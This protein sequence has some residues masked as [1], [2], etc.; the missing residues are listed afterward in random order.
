[1][2]EDGGKDDRSRP[3]PLLDQGREPLEP[4]GRHL[5]GHVRDGHGEAQVGL[6]RA[7]AEDRLRVGHARKRPLHPHP[8][9]GEQAHE[10]G[11]DQLEDGLH[12]RK[13]H[14]DVDLGELGLAVGAQVLVAEAADDLEIAVHPR[15]HEDL[16][17]DLGRLGQRVELSVVDPRRYQ[18]VARALRRRLREHR[19]L[20]L[21]EARLVHVAAHLHGHAVAQLQVALEPGPAQVEIAILEPNVLGG[22]ELVLDGKGWRLRFGQD[23]DLAGQHLEGARGQLRVHRLRGP[24]R[25]LAHDRENVLAAH[26]VRGAVGLGGHLGPGHHLADP[27]A[28]AEVQE[29]HPPEV[30]S[31]GHPAHEGDGLPDRGVG[32]RPAH[33]GAGQRALGLSHGASPSSARGRAPRAR[34][35]GRS[36]ACRA[37]P[38]RPSGSRRR[39]GWRRSAPRA[40]RPSSSSP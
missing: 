32:Q 8:G 17:E 24:A 34:L 31:R 4:Q 2:P 1:M 22:V 36:R 18:I 30:A 21:E 26:L 28:V 19:G 37:R 14:L 12:A 29:H 10:Q 33:V 39:R 35:P 20:D 6:V 15:D 11:L 13:R 23:A 25:D 3:G 9:E 40:C 5:L 16:L 7:V 38:T 27:L